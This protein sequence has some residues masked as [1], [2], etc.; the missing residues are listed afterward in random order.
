MNKIIIASGP[1]IVK[2][3]K[4]LLDISGDDVFWKFIGGKVRADEALQETT[5]RRAKEEL[6]VDVV[7][8]NKEPYLMYFSKLGE[9]DVEVILVHWLAGCSGEIKPG[10][11]VKKWQ[12][13]SLNNLP[14]NLGPNIIP[15]LKHFNF[16]E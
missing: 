16:L 14:N 7:I 3:N 5:I 8:K 6:G 11:E 13:H 2:D 10:Q 1:V 9:E 4:V 15:A 12:W